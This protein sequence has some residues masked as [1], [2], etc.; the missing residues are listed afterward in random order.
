[1]VTLLQGDCRQVLK[2]MQ[3]CSVHCCVTS[4]PYWGLRSYLPNDHPN[5][6]REMGLE[7]TPDAYVAALVA[8]FREVR[9]ILRPDGV[10]FLNLGDSYARD[11]GKGGSGPNGKNVAYSDT[12]TDAARIMRESKGSSDGGVGRGDRAAVRVGGGGIK[13]K[14]ACGIPWR[15]AFALQADGWW[16]RQEIVWVK[17]NPMPESVTDRFTKCTESIFLLAKSQRYFFDQEAVKEPGQN[18]GQRDRKPGSAFVDGTPGRSKQS[19]GKKC[20]FSAGRNRRNAWFINTR[21]YSGAHFAVFPP[22]LILPCILAGCPATVCAKCGAPWER[23]MERTDEPDTSALGSRFDTGKTAARD[24]GNRTQHGEITLKRSIGFRPTCKC[25]ANTQP[26]TVLDPFGGSGTTG[27]VAEANGRNSILI[28]LS[29]AYCDL[30]KKRTA[31]M[32]LFASAS[33][34]NAHDCTKKL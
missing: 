19:G 10:L 5:K 31:Q 6:D 30:A 7:Q 33:Q 13:P 3:D 4:P 27:E 22:A 17:G 12:Y 2:T 15:V 34:N 20:D 8:V 23:K 26:G 9:R 1:M 11:P 29:T 32:G 24:G 28:E 25:N 21:P 18:W 16:L 14:D